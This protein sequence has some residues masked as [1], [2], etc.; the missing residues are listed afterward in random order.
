MFSFLVIAISHGFSQTTVLVKGE[1]RSQDGTPLSGASISQKNG[2]AAAT[3]NR[4]GFFVIN[5]PG[6]TMLIF[7]HV[8][9]E[10][11]EV[12]AAEKMEVTLAPQAFKL[13][14][15]EIVV[16]KGYGKSRKIAVSSS[17]ASV[18]GKDIQNQ[19]AY[20]VGTLLQGKAT[21]V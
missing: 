14:E 1:I 8:G 19:T 16:D 13:E 17:I 7:T 2:G 11:K 10:P 4:A 9:Y 18:S 12:V 20:N 6:G 21:G 15:V 3:S 5:V